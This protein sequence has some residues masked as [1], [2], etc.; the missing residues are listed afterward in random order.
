VRFAQE[1][2][3]GPRR[4]AAHDPGL[5]RCPHRDT[6]TAKPFRH[7]PGRATPECP[8]GHPTRDATARAAM[9][10]F[11]K[12]TIS[13]TTFGWDGPAGEGRCAPARDGSGRRCSARAQ[14]ARCG[15][16]RCR[17]GLPGT[18]IAQLRRT[19]ARWEATAAWISRPGDRR[20]SCLRNRVNPSLARTYQPNVVGEIVSLGKAA[21]AA[22]AVASGVGQWVRSGERLRG[23]AASSRLRPGRGS[24]AY[25]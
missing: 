3:R 19:P 15:K 23:S 7:C 11:P 14:P 5:G 18:A 25:G 21:S 2:R 8:A 1:S 9:V 13:P 6:V 10:T 12:E 17:P 24:H 16:R 4:G 22:G 20:G